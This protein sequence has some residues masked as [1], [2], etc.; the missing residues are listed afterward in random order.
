MSD[1][2]QQQA[3]ALIRLLDLKKENRFLKFSDGAEGAQSLLKY[4]EK[5]G[6]DYFV[7]DGVAE[8]IH[9]AELLPLLISLTDS[10]RK[11]LLM[12]VPLST[13]IN[14]AY[15]RPDDNLDPLRIIRWPL[16]QWMNFCQKAINHKLDSM[17]V[18]GSWHY[19]GLKPSSSEVFKSCGFI[20]FHRLQS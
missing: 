14:G 8:Y 3:E 6:I 16:E 15:V 17:Y 5:E 12:I 20:Q 1:L 11:S 2:H 19:P 9:P 7:L 18:T 13:E 4:S 10:L